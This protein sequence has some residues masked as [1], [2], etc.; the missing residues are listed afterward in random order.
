MGIIKGRQHGVAFLPTIL[1]AFVL[2]MA[3]AKQRPNTELNSLKQVGK[4][5]FRGGNFNSFIA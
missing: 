1:M 5:K 2:P 4:C 3:V